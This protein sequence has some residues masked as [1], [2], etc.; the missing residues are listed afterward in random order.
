MGLIQ[1]NTNEEIPTEAVKRAIT[2]HVFPF[3]LTEITTLRIY[4]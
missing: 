2:T 1:D 3:Y 4:E